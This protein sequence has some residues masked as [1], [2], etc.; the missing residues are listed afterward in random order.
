MT[1][2]NRQQ[3]ISFTEH[4][5]P[6]S[7][8]LA[9]RRQLHKGQRGPMTPYTPLNIANIHNIVLIPATPLN[10]FWILSISMNSFYPP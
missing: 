1:M 6:Q 9:E 4:R 3:E 8:K 2:K 10:I 7:G 5:T